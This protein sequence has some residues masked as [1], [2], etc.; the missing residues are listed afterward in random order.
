MRLRKVLIAV[1]LCAFL[2]GTQSVL[3]APVTIELWHAMGG[4]NGE[5][6]QTIVNAFN[7]SQSDVIV[8]LQFQGSYYDLQ[9]KF[10]ASLAA[11]KPPALIQLPIEGTGVFGPTGALADLSEYLEKDPVVNYDYFQ[12][13][14]LVDSRY[15][16][17]FLAI[18]FNRSNPVLFYNVDHFVEAGLGTDPPETWEEVVAYSKKLTITD[19]DGRVTRHGFSPNLHWWTLMP[20]I[21]SNGGNIADPETGAPRFD[22]P[23]VAEVMALIWLT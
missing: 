15:Q 16:G 10:M 14:L 21:W 6:L 17:K 8:D 3:A 1:L 4:V 13:G 22:S 2:A 7:E 11:R 5:T 9:Q 20:M 23:E 12:P 18:P 19:K